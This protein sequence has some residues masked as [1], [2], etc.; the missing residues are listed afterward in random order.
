MRFYSVDRA[1]R[2]GVAMVATLVLACSSAPSPSSSSPAGASG[3]PST[4]SVAPPAPTRSANP[5]PTPLPTP[6][7]TVNRTLP[8]PFATPVQPGD[9]FDISWSPVDDPEAPALDGSLSLAS[10]ITSVRWGAGAVVAYESDYSRG[11]MIWFSPDL[12]S[13]RRVVPVGPAGRRVEVRQVLVGGPG[14]VAFG[15]DQPEEDGQTA[16]VM[17]VSTDGEHWDQIIDLPGIAHVWARPG[18]IVGFG[19]GTW[20]SADGRT[21]REAGPSPF[22]DGEVARWV[23]IV[24]DG[25]TAIV[26]LKADSEGPT[27]AYRLGTDGRWRQ[28]AELAGEVDVAARGPRGYVVLGFRED[29]GWTSW[30]SGDG[31]AWDAYAG[32]EAPRTLVVTPAGFVSTSQRSYYTGC[33]GFDPAQQVAQTWTSGDGITWRRMPEDPELDHVDLPLLFLDGNRLLAVGL[34]WAVDDGSSEYQDRAR[35]SVWQSQPLAEPRDHTPPTAGPGC[36]EVE[37]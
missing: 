10:F 32:P 24:E 5:I 11:P 36:G 14:L 25:E 18:V 23:D 37:P 17:W 12:A 1:L 16:P 15:L 29:M 35:P 28:L 20:L 33:A 13:W 30:V 4:P 6:L 31:I 7:P 34:A 9:P 21:W 27:G 22:A 19:K 2:S 26:F 3:P 8:E